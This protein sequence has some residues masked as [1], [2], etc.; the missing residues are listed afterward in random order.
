[1][2]YNC[3]KFICRKWVFINKYKKVFDLKDFGDVKIKE[4]FNKIKAGD[5]F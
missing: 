4:L 1:M 2:A 5:A 3:T